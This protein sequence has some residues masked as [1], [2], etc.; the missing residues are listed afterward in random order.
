VLEKIADEARGWI[1][2]GFWDAIT[3]YLSEKPKKSA[4]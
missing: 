4:T 3:K 2:L 1:A